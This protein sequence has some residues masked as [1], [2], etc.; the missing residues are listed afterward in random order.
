MAVEGRD[1]ERREPLTHVHLC[2]AARIQ[3]S[4]RACLRVFARD[5]VPTPAGAHQEAGA[6]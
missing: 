6:Q 3:S 1:A 5:A 2:H 4:S